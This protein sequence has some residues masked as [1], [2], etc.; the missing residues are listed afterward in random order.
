MFE[1]YLCIYLCPNVYKAL[2]T[3]LTGIQHLLLVCRL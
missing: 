3:Q 1:L 2:S